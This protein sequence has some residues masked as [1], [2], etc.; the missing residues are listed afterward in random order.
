E[1]DPEIGSA[2][3]FDIYGH[4]SP[5][6]VTGEAPALAHGPN[7]VAVNGKGNGSYRLKLHMIISGETIY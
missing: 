1:Y 4:T 3:L 7:T 6:P 2:M 5:V